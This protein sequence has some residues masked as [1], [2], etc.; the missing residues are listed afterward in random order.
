MLH[1]SCKRAPLHL[2][3]EALASPHIL[4]DRGGEEPRLSRAAYALRVRVRRALAVPAP[5]RG[6]QLSYVACA[7]RVRGCRAL[8]VPA[9]HR[10]FQLSYVAYVLR[11][12]VRLALAELALH[13]D[14]QFSY[15]VDV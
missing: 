3:P 9:S 1:T 7:L 2:V 15:V 13:R 10:G 12:C 5:H 14:G 8:A 4:V 6:F 11:V